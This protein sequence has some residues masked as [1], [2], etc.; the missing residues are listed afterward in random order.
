M[1]V[2]SFLILKKMDCLYVLVFDIL[3]KGN[4]AETLMSVGI[5]L[6]ACF[7]TSVCCTEQ[8]ATEALVILCMRYPVLFAVCPQQSLK[9]I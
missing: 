7:P 9:K 1:E 5:W 6:C 4:V 2:T 3:K 8:I